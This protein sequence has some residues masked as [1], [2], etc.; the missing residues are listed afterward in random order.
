MRWDTNCH[1][2][3]F[4]GF[5]S[6]GQISRIAWALAFRF[7]SS[8]STAPRF[9]GRITECWILYVPPNSMAASMFPLDSIGLAYSECNL[10]VD[11]SRPMLISTLTPFLV[12]RR[13]QRTDQ[14]ILESRW[15][16]FRVVPVWQYAP[17]RWGLV[18]FHHVWLR[19]TWTVRQ[20]AIFWGV[21][22]DGS[23]PNHIIRAL[24]QGK[25]IHGIS[26]KTHSSCKVFVGTSLNVALL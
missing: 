24:A 20:G 17:T 3:N 12:R 18:E 8:P 11:A 13:H 7:Y 21:G 10:A 14:R 5:G 19:P 23:V 6:T 22:D 9:R 15:F 2:I 16:D 26:T 25:Q 4:D 1:P